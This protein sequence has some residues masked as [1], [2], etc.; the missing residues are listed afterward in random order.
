M[1]DTVSA[2]DDHIHDQHEYPKDYAHDYEDFGLADHDSLHNMDFQISD[3]SNLNLD[4]HPLEHIQDQMYE[5]SEYHFGDCSSHKEAENELEF[6]DNEADYNIDDDNIDFQKDDAE[7]SHVTHDYVSPGGSSYWIPVVSDHIKP[8]INSIFDSYRAA[9]SMYYNYASLAGFDVRLGPIRTTE[10][11]IITQRQ[12]L[13]NRKYMVLI[14]ILLLNLSNKTIISCLV[15]TICFCPVQ[16]G[17][18][19][20]HKRSLFTIRQSKILVPQ[21]HID[22]IL[23]FR[24]VL[25]FAVGWFLISRTVLESQF[26]HRFQGCKIPCRED[27]IK[28][29]SIPSL[30][31]DFKVVEKKLNVIFWA[32]ETSKYNYN[33][34]GDVVSLDA[35]DNMNKYDMVFVPFTGIDNH[36]KCVT[37]GARLLSREDGSSYSWLLT[38]FLKA[39][40]K[41]PTLVLTDQDPS[42]IKV[43]NQVFA[44]STHRCN[45]V[46]NDFNTATTVL[47]FITSSPIEPHASKVNT[48]KIFYQVQKEISDSDKTCFQMS[49]TSNNGVETI[50]IL[51]KQKNIT[52]RQPSSP[53]VDDKVEEYH[54]DSLTEDTQ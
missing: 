3:T 5:N 2:G 47:R 23:D 26:L 21:E 41:Q 31:F 10:F 20:I 22:C 14:N 11:D 48:R 50:L 35:T 43:V 9:L 49:V 7:Q 44:M 16:R 6:N 12:L 1:D 54:Y 19:I 28:E 39:F 36:K 18:L 33:D 15:R 30:S 37:F 42:L 38:T 34:F 53:V 8:K 13:C 4:E 25:T 46:V 51:E 27:A 17:N 45:K 29:K 24:V 52:T 32:D 40:K